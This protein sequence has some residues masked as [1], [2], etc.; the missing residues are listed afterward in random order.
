MQLTVTLCVCELVSVDV[1]IT[2]CPFFSICSR[3][4]VKVTT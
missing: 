4:A 2:V 1:A 3:P